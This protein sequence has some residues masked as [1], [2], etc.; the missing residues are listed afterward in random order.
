MLSLLFLVIQFLQH[1]G[2]SPA[3]SVP[4]KSQIYT[5]S[6]GRTHITLTTEK[7]IHKNDNS[8]GNF[9]P[10]GA[11]PLMLCL[12]CHIEAIT[13]FIFFT[14]CLRE[15]PTTFAQFWRHGSAPPQAAT[16]VSIQPSN[17]YFFT[18]SN[19]YFRAAIF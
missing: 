9:G 19:F 4:L 7:I 14:K 6:D 13:N 11:R 12:C 18:S 16:L 10:G 1:Y 5:P 8:A 2:L 3:N 17:F 15:Q